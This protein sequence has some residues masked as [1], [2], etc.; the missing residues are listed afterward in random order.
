MR[1]LLYPMLVV[2][3][4]AALPAQASDKDYLYYRD[5][6]VPPFQESREF[7]DM[8]NRPG[9]YEVTLVSESTGPLT[10]R[11]VRVHDE[12][13]VTLAQSRSYTA[14]NHEFHSRFDNPQGTEDLIVEIANSNPVSSARVSV[15]V[16]E[17]P[18]Q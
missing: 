14:G 9:V 15:I 6:I 13:E 2:L 10:F 18:H 8:P 12:K 7:F 5:A 4:S 3:L 17:L 1:W 16:V 11:V